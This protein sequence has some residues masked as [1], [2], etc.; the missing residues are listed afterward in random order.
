MLIYIYNVFSPYPLISERFPSNFLAL[1]KSYYITS[2][3]RYKNMG[4]F[5]RIITLPLIIGLICFMS[6]SLYLKLNQ[7]P[8]NWLHCAL[9]ITVSIII[10]Y[11]VGLI[12]S[13]KQDFYYDDSIFKRSIKLILTLIIIAASILLLTMFTCVVLKNM[14]SWKI[15]TEIIFI[16]FTASALITGE[17]SLIISSL[18]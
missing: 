14:E 17:S 1:H 6:S 4:T 11:Y 12:V 9:L 18:I 5:K 13:A 2:K 3:R 16:S 15:I 8:F 10:G 7:A